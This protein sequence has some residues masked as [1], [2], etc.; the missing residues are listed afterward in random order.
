MENKKKFDKSY[1]EL[2]YTA[3]GWFI[4]KNSN[5]YGI[6]DSNDISTINAAH[7]DEYKEGGACYVNK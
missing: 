6:M 7:A 5:N 4:F 2:K 1:T 3:N